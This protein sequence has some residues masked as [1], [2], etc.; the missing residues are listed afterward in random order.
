MSTSNEEPETISLYDM[1]EDESEI[2]EDQNYV[3]LS[4]NVLNQPFACNRHLEPCLNVVFDKLDDAKACYNVYAR[5]KGVSR[6][7]D[8]DTER[9]GPECAETRVGCKTM[10]DTWVV[11]KF[12]ENH[13]YELLTPKSTSMLC[14]HRVITNAQRNLIDTLNETEAGSQSEKKYKHIGQTLQKVHEE[15]LAMQDVCDVDDSGSPDNTTL[16]NQV[17][18][19]LPITLRDCPHVPSKE[20]LKI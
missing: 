2:N 1:V 15:L 9:I 20:G 3:D 17:L 12:V 13:N 16:N 18:S 8:E 10:I 4:L 19:N 14:G 7:S 5:Q 6:K 11:C